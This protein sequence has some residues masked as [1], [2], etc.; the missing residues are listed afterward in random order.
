MDKA[1][2]AFFRLAQI[3]RDEALAELYRVYDLLD[4]WERAGRHRIAA[5][6]IEALEGEN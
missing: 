4:S 5:Q 2:K 3:Q 1:E 6:L